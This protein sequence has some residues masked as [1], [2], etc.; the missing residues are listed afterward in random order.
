[1]YNI[2]IVD[3][4]YAGHIKDLLS[5]KITANYD[6]ALDGKQGYEKFQNSLDNDKQ[7]SIIIM[8]IN[9]PVMDGIDAT[10]AIRAIDKNI[11]IVIYSSMNVSKF[12]NKALEA[13]ANKFIKKGDNLIDEVLFWLNL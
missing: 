3:D 5:N 11:P 8:D 10:A 1:M 4:N 12:I 7:Y 6:L 13:G 9:M 2:L